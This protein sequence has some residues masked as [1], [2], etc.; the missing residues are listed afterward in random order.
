[1]FYSPFSDISLRFFRGK[2]LDLSLPNLNKSGF[3]FR[4]C[5]LI[6]RLF[7]KTQ[8][9]TYLATPEKVKIEYQE[10]SL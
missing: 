1:M 4:I 9:Y 6:K 8:V 7:R 5:I 2:A 10:S 3:R